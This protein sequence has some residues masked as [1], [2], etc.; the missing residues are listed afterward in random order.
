M[1]LHSAVRAS[2]VYISKLLIDYNWLI[3][4]FHCFLKQDF[5][6]EEQKFFVTYFL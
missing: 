6:Q 4:L 3:S 5:C 1:A 2:V